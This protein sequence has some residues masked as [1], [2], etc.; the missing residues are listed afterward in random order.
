MIALPTTPALLAQYRDAIADHR[1][2]LEQLE[3]KRLRWLEAGRK[4]A[5]T[6]WL[7]S[8]RAWIAALEYVVAA[9]GGGDAYGPQRTEKT[10]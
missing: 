5:P 2:C 4:D 1:M 8:Y 3:S 6:E 9:Y 10:R 7:A